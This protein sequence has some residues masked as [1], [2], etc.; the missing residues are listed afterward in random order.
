LEEGGSLFVVDGRL[1]VSCG[2]LITGYRR[3]KVIHM[4]GPLQTAK[5]GERYEV[6][7]LRG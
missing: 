5:P 1:D 3:R 6:R 7:F 4:E 2:N